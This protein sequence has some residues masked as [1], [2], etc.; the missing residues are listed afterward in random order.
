MKAYGGV[1][2]WNQVF[3]TS[4]LVGGQGSTSRLGRYT[5]RGRR[6]MYSLDRRLCDLGT[7]L[8][9]VERRKILLLSELELR[10]FGRSYRRRLSSDNESPTDRIP[11]ARRLPTMP[12][13][14][15]WLGP[16]SDCC[17][18]RKDFFCASEAFSSAAEAGLYLTSVRR[19]FVTSFDI[20]LMLSDCILIF[21]KFLSMVA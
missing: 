19:Y 3:L 16:Y 6:P 18:E 15:S 12:I 17:V 13:E 9:D 21:V 20:C 1:D 10:I 7:G 14:L 5:P 4:A 2:V 8:D 11:I